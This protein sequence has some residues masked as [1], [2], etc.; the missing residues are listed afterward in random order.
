M[1]GIFNPRWL[2]TFLA[3]GIAAL[4]LSTLT[5]GAEPQTERVSVSSLG[6][7]G[8]SASQGASLSG[9]GR[10][11]VFS[12]DASNLVEGDTNSRDIFI[13]DRQR[14]ETFL[15]SLNSAGEQAFKPLKTAIQRKARLA[16]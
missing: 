16:T 5:W 9:D 10:Y 4:V 15:A 14:N 1:P 3:A 11:V 6:V 13:R 7:E 8:T 12:S 2:A